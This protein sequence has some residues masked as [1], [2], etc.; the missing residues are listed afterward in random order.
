MVIC[1]RYSV[2]CGVQVC[3]WLRDRIFVEAGGPD[4]IVSKDGW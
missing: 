3:Q 1:Y 2:C 4:F